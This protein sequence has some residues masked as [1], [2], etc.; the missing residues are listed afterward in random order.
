MDI[1]FNAPMDELCWYLFE[2]LATVFTK[3]HA[4]REEFENGLV[5]VKFVIT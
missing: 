4:V 1:A 2:G 5:I 3:L